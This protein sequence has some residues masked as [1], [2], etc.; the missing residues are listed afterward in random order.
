MNKK[1]TLICLIVSV[2]MLIA[3]SSYATYAWLTVNRR[4][5]DEGMEMQIDSDSLLGMA[6]MTYWRYKSD[7]G[8][9]VYAYSSNSK[10]TLPTYDSVFVEDN[11][12]CRVYIRV[13]VFGRT[14]NQGNSF[15]VTL[16]IKSKDPSDEIFAENKNYYYYDPMNDEKTDSVA[17]Y[18]S[19]VVAVKCGVIK[20]LNDVPDGDASKQTI[21]DTAK[22]FFADAENGT[23]QKFI[24]VN[25]NTVSKVKEIEFEVSGYSDSRIKLEGE[26]N[27]YLLY[28]YFEIAYDE[29]LVNQMMETWELELGD[30]TFEITSDFSK[31]VLNL[32]EDE[33]ETSGE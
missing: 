30:D 12:D 15:T 14:V 21:V 1:G 13:P 16:S 6:M 9:V 8:G 7:E 3:A 17:L 25:G 28:V 24:T 23:A 29:D 26:D 19:N 31:F 22:D 5:S 4:V 10:I 18:L 2:A 20:G 11:G 33:T 27:A 32:E